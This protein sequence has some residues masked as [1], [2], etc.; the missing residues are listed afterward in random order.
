MIL[1]IEYTKQ[2]IYTLFNN[3]NS[4]L[5]VPITVKVLRKDLFIRNLYMNI[6]NEK[7][8]L[9]IS[10]IRNSKTFSKATTSNSLLQYLCDA[11]INEIVLKESII[12]VEFFKSNADSDKSSPRVRVNI[13][14]LRKKLNEY[15]QAEGKEDAHIVSI[16]K[17]QYNLHFTKRPP[18][19]SFY[20]KIKLKNVV[21]YGLILIMLVVFL[22]SNLPPKKDAIWGSYIEK[23]TSLY[24]GDIFGIMGNT[25]TGNYG[26]NR[27]YAIN[28]LSDYYALSQKNEDVKTNTK[29]A[30]YTY[31]TGMAV[32]ATQRIEQVFQQFNTSPSIK[33][34]S[35]SSIADI[36]QENAI[37][38]G[39][40]KNNNH[41]IHFFNQS[42]KYFRISNDS[43]FLKGHPQLAD[44]SFYLNSSG[45]TEEYAVVSNIP[46]PGNTNQLLFF[47]NHDIGVS[48]TIEFYTNRESLTS[49]IK[50]NTNN[51]PYFTAVFK[52]EGKS[53]T[54]TKLELILTS[55]IE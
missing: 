13:Y 5:T 11:S 8:Q 12:D 32:I 7:K 20:S 15:Y 29:P 50:K 17:G 2:Q 48:S 41:F 3:F 54:N 19:K 27:D 26:W 45:L 30:N 55:A 21:P 9:L 53:R 16:E 47:S 28:N 18:I 44:T 23:P 51:T 42:N 38:V 43:L 37:Y 24:I 6:N 22:V 33:F 35:Q 31:T 10:S 1:N 4:I 14:N 40:T 52:A 49:F 46:G 34:I 36:K 25:A 39:P